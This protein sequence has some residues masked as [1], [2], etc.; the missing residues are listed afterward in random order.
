MATSRSRA[1]LAG[2][3]Y[4]LLALAPAIAWAFFFVSEPLPNCSPFDSATL[5][6]ERIISHE[7]PGRS[8]LPGLAAVVLVLVALAGCY[9]ADLAS[10]RRGAYILL[11]LG[12]GL[13]VASFPPAPWLAALLVLP[14]LFALLCVPDA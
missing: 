6:L 2:G 11:F 13:A 10:S 4:M 1:N 7:N 5:Q 9:F 12:A 3:L 14:L 8:W